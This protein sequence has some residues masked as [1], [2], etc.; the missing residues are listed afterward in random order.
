[1]ADEINRATARTQSSLLES[2]EEKQV[3]V[4]GVTSKLD[5]PFLVIATQNPLESQ[6]TFPLPEAQLDRFLIKIKMN[7]PS[8]DESIEI[9]KRFDCFEFSIS[10]TSRQPREGEKDG[11]DY[12]FLSPDNFA[13]RVEN[14][15][16]LEWEEV[17]AGTSYGTLKSE[18]NR[19]W[20]N[21]H[22]IIF[23]VD[24][25]GGMNLKKYF[26]PDA[27]ALFVMPPSVEV[28][29]QRLRSRGTES[30]EN[31]AKRLARSAAELKMADQ[32]DVT[33]VNDILSDAVDKTQQ[34]IN[35]Y[36]K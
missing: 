9:L 13:Q 4:D 32:F 11:I 5:L 28:L 21:G 24:V 22:V 10:A 36:L 35:N 6:G 23:D 29:E 26:G 34:V 2:M 7:Y 30:E 25:N 18:I 16:F 27:L 8:H 19:I 31:I 3:S 14:D 15:E 33:I 20:D 17:Y 12:Y 1:M